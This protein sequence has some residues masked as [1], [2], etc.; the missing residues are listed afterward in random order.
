MDKK[1][2]VNFEMI[3]AKAV[4]DIGVPAN[5]RGYY[6]L[7]DAVKIAVVDKL[8]VS[9]MTAKIYTPLANQYGTT[10]QKVS[11]AIARAI[12]IGWDRSDLATLEQYFGNRA[13]NA[14]QFQRI[15]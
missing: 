9:D 15:R 1:M 4:R 13:F 3:V 14:C 2:P 7:I 8:A 11:G 10:D 6:C 5:I 12:Q